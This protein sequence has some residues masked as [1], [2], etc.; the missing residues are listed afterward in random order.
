M[1]PVFNEAR[2]LAALHERLAEVARFLTSKYGLKTEI[3]YVDD[4]SRDDTPEIAR[5]LAAAR[6]PCRAISAR[7]PRC[8]PA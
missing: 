1:V 2:G 8:S 7:R 5:G 3:V 4:G 6:S